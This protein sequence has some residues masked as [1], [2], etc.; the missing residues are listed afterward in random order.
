MQRGGRSRSNSFKGK[1]MHD[2]LHG[3]C[4]VVD[5]LRKK[6]SEE[7]QDEVAAAAAANTPD[8]KVGTDGHKIRRDS[9]MP[10][11]KPATVTIRQ[12]VK[13]RSNHVA[14]ETISEPSHHEIET[15]RAL[16]TRYM[17]PN[18]ES[19][20]VRDDFAQQRAVLE[21]RAVRLYLYFE[22][23]ESNNIKLTLDEFQ[24]KCIVDDVLYRLIQVPAETTIRG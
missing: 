15:F 8:R 5:D 6:E 24:L 3:K 4:S 19:F 12:E 9:C 22:S 13:R 23:K 18:P 10:K 16:V 17:D 21:E 20:A 7:D 2:A 14:P 11:N 1:E